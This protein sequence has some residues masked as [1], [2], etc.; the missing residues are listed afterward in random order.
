MDLFTQCFQY[1]LI[2][3][4]PSFCWFW[5]WRTGGIIVGA[6]PGLT[7]T[8]AWLSWSP[9]PLACRRKRAHSVGWVIAPRLCCASTAILST[10]PSPANIAT[11]FDGYPMAMGGKAR[12][13]SIRH[14]APW[15]GLVGWWLTA[16]L[17]PLAAISP[18]FGPAEIFR[19]AKFGVQPI[20]SF[21]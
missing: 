13:P 17:A 20:A 8:W 2:Y 1:C 18:E 15:W 11:L 7:P 19:V 3:S 14:S 10:F 9:S 4:R 21:R 16:L 5:C 12:R 6:L